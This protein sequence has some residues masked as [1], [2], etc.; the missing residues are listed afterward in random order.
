MDIKDRILKALENL[1][2]IN[3]K[4][5]AASRV[6]KLNAGIVKKYAHIDFTPPDGVAKAAARG[7]ELRKKYGR[8]GLA[9]GVARAVQLKNKETVSPATAKR[10]YKFFS[11]HSAFKKNHDDKKPDGGPSNSYISWLLWGGDAGVAWANKLWNQMEA[12]DKKNKAGTVSMSEFK[13][14]YVMNDVDKAFLEDMLDWIAAGDKLANKVFKEGQN[15]EVQELAEAYMVMSD[16]IS[17]EIK[18]IM[19]NASEYGFEYSKD[20]FNKNYSN[21]SVRVGMKVKWSFG[22]GTATGTIVQLY[23]RTVKKN[24]KS[25]LITRNGTPENPALLIEQENGDEV[26]KLASE[27]SPI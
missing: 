21:S 9:V 24:I 19:E 14:R 4:I 11:R 26:L 25:S 1:A 2:S 7:L 22:S 17:D 15:E 6:L 20:L 13:D 10:M 12:A 16:E 8:G 3:N 18:D 23:R 5:E 27:V